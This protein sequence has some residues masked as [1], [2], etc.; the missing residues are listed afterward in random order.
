M[1]AR[2]LLLCTLYMA[3]YIRADGVP[4]DPEFNKMWY[5]H[6]TGQTGGPAGVDINVVPVWQK[7]ITGEGVVVAVVSD[8]LDHTHAD[9]IMNY[10]SQASYDFNDMDADPMPRTTDPD[11]EEGTST[12]GVIA[13]TANNS[14]CGVGVAYNAKIGGIRMTDGQLTDAMEAA[15][16]S[17]KNNHIDIYTNTWGPKDDGKSF[18][19]P[20]HL[21]KK[22][23][24]LGTKDGR[25]GKGNIYIWGTGDGGLMDDDCN[26]DGYVNSIHTVAIGCIDNHGLSPYTTEHCSSM[27]AVTFCG[28]SH[29]ENGK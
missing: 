23:L 20:G 28:R 15:A 12:A 19:K 3:V 16:L 7:G 29:R 9:L 2:L 11:N 22:A 17:F 4:T 13:A 6:N 24:K 10:D 21:A 18:G 1:R 14:I 8:G 25:N 5:L 27:L 26:C